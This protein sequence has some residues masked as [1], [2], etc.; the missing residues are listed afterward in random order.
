MKLPLAD[1]IAHLRRT[2]AEALDAIRDL[3]LARTLDGSLVSLEQWLHLDL[4]LPGDAILAEL[5]A[6]WK[7]LGP[8]PAEDGSLRERHT[9]MRTWL[10][11]AV[12]LLEPIA[13][14]AGDVAERLDAL[15]HEQAHLAEDPAYDEVR[16]VLTARM[17]ERRDLESQIEGALPSLH[18]LE[19]AGPIL[20]EYAARIEA[21]AA[22][23]GPTA[24]AT[25]ALVGG[26]LDA[27]AALVVPHG[28]TLTPPDSRDPAEAAACLRRAA[29]DA[30]ERAARLST[31][32]DVRNAAVAALHADIE[33]ITG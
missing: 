4:P 24:V 10:A 26:F 17:A 28:V 18:L 5:G 16:A 21:R 13:R 7:V 20:Q 19:R 30:G 23:A 15:R 2:S 12:A 6:R 32:L 14:D 3:S 29:A 25:T 11:S 31:T 27:A 22:E 9:G 1:E 8:P 33:S